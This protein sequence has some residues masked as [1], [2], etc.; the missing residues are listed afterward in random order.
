MHTGANVVTATTDGNGDG[1]VT[2]TIPQNGATYT[3]TSGVA[4][5]MDLSG[6]AYVQS[7]ALNTSISSVNLIPNGSMFWRGVLVNQTISTTQGTAGSGYYAT[8]NGD[9]IDILP[10]QNAYG[11]EPAGITV[12]FNTKINFSAISKIKCYCKM[13]NKY[14]PMP[15]EG[16]LSIRYADTIGGT[17]TSIGA[18]TTD[19]GSIEADV[20]AVSGEHYVCVNAYH[21][22]TASKLY[23]LFTE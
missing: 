15:T 1:T 23:Q 12:W 3:F 8:V 9:A 14:A 19:V 20:S 16:S 10:P 2:M 7:V 17:T 11:S 13:G 18:I 4:K 6:N 22:V 21:F 5:S